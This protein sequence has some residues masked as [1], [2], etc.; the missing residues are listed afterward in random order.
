MIDG[1]VCERKRG[2]KTSELVE[3]IR[4]FLGEDRRMSI[5][6]I[7]IRFVAGVVTVQRIIY[8]DLKMREICAKFVPKL[9][10]DEQ[11]LR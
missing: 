9:L 2:V 3:K 5:K 10:R 6:T 7:R 4:N 8:G 1:E 11:K